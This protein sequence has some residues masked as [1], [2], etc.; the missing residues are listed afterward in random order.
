[1][2]VSRRSENHLTRNLGLPLGKN[3]VMV[4]EYCT[5][6]VRFN[7][8]VLNTLDLPLVYL[9]IRQSPAYTGY[10]SGKTSR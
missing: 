7:Q 4:L 1:M 5:G 2:N 8:R 3:L 10:R 9:K 6:A